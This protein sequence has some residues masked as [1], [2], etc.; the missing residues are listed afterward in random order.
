MFL[1]FVNSMQVY[2]AN[3]NKDI[4][5]NRSWGGFFCSLFVSDLGRLQNTWRSYQYSVVKRA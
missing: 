2:P 5:E 1:P 4:Y 3:N